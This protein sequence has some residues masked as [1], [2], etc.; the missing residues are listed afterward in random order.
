MNLIE[1]FTANFKPGA[2]GLVGT[3]DLMGRAIREAQKSFTLD[4]LP[5]R[6][7]HAL[8]FGGLRLDRHSVDSPTSLHIFESSFDIYL[9]KAQ[10]RN[11]AQEN[12]IGN[13]CDNQTDQ[14]CIIDFGLSEVEVNNVLAT[15]LQ[16]VDEQVNFPIVGLAAVWLDIIL[17]RVWQ[18]NPFISKNSMFCSQLVRHCYQIAKRDFLGPEIDISNTAPEHIHQA[19]LKSG[20]IIEWKEV[21]KWIE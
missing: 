8:I 20:K 17:K 13:W 10:M 19:G 18:R 11:G 1:F 21:E 9:L 2:I 12:W 5:S 15:A 7:C 3:T 6:W 4:G 14:A 16:L